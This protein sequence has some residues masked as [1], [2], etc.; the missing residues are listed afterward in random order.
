[1]SRSYTSS[2]LWRLYGVAE[3]ICFLLQR[4]IE[5]FNIKGKWSSTDVSFKQIRIFSFQV[6]WRRR[7]YLSFDVAVS[8]NSRRLHKTER[9]RFPRRHIRDG[10]HSWKNKFHIRQH[11]TSSL[12]EGR[13][14]LDYCCLRHTENVVKFAAGICSTQWGSTFLNAYPQTYFN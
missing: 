13:P 12:Q 7:K 8:S 11:R 14:I 4:E 10:R 2:P 5:R 3:Q 1:M 9:K 6:L